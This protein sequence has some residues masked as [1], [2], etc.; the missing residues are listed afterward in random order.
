VVFF[1]NRIAT[2]ARLFLKNYDGDDHALL[3]SGRD[4]W[5]DSVYASFHALQNHQTILRMKD[6][7][8]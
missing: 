7:R 1:S 5:L 8:Y 2:M 6:F 3:D 4:V